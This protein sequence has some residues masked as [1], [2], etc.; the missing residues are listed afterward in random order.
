MGYVGLLTGP[1]LIGGLA[2]ITG[3]T[4][5]LGLPAL[6]ALGIAAGAGFAMSKSGG[7]RPATA[8]AVRDARRDQRSRE[9]SRG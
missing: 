8:Q 4:A 9:A 6:L 2:S 5:A 7:Q 1:V 3:L